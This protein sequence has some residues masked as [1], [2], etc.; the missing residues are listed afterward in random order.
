[1]CD[2]QT[3]DQRRV[4]DVAQCAVWHCISW[5][6]EGHGVYF[7]LVVSC[8]GSLGTA[9]LLYGIKCKKKLLSKPIRYCGILLFFR[10][11][12]AVLCSVVRTF[13]KRVWLHSWS[14]TNRND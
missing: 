9:L 11:M 7:Y 2:K 1:M 13:Q 8:F 12:A 4:Y 6:D 3:C 10:C 5:D 14:G